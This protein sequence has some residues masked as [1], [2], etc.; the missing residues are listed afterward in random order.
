MMGKKVLTNLNDPRD[1][2]RAQNSNFS[3]VKYERM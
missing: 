2:T 1:D 3:C